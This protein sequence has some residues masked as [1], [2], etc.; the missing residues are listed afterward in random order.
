MQMFASFILLVSIETSR[1]NWTWRCEEASSQSQP[2]CLGLKLFRF[3]S[4]A[5]K[6]D[7]V[8]HNLTHKHTPALRFCSGPERRTF[9]GVWKSAWWWWWCLCAAYF[10][11]QVIY[12]RRKYSVSPPTT[13]GPPAFERIF[14]AQSVPLCA[15]V[16]VHSGSLT[17]LFSW[18]QGI[19]LRKTKLRAKNPY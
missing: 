18:Y 12:A 1:M 4:S 8:L 17:C 16:A 3:A 6:A 14:R 11:L 15:C 13:S 10:S 19:N 5:D 9:S 7:F 2:V